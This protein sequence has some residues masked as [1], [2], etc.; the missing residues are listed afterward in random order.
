M[1]TK[2]ESLRLGGSLAS[3]TPL[4]S[5]AAGTLWAQQRYAATTPD[6]SDLVEYGNHG[7]NALTLTRDPEFRY[8]M[9]FRVCLG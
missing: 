2:G 3:L 5:F 6:P 1:A 8:E 4:A 9:F 7:I